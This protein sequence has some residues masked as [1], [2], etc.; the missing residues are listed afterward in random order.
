MTTTDF[1]RLDIPPGKGQTRENRCLVDRCEAAGT[2]AKSVG[3]YHW[4]AQ[5]HEITISIFVVY[6][7]L[8]RCYLSVR[9]SF[10]LFCL[11]GSATFGL[12]FLRRVEG[13]PSWQIIR[14]SLTPRRSAG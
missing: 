4:F 11:C 7:V 3:N 14:P 6:R 5:A 1:A 9:M 10:S 13:V 8:S 2:S 12:A